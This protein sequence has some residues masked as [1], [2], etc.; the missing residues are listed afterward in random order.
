MDF[1]RPPQCCFC[2]LCVESPRVLRVTFG[3]VD[4]CPSGLCSDYDKFNGTHEIP[5]HQ[6]CVWAANGPQIYD[7]SVKNQID[8]L[9]ACNSFLVQ[10]ALSRDG[11]G[12]K[13]R[14][15]A[16]SGSAAYGLWEKTCPGDSF[17]CQHIG[18]LELKTFQACQAT[19]YVDFSQASCSV[20]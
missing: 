8:T 13:V 9:P 7:P 1:E 14:V 19:V 15:T 5:H 10:V 3:G 18:E 16:T 11:D 6:G 4:E 17:D 2:A 12:V 20:C